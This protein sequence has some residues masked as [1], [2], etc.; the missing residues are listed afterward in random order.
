MR[1]C[2]LLA[3]LLLSAS[4]AAQEHFVRVG[5]SRQLTLDGQPYY[6]IGTNAWYLPI[7]AS[8]GQGGDYRRLAAELNALCKLGVRNLRILVGADGHP[9]ARKVQP[10]L[11]TAPGEYNDTLL[12]GLDRLLVEMGKRQMKA[13]L[14]LNNSWSWSG[15]YTS[16]IHWSQGDE[17]EVVDTIEWKQ[18]CNHAALF[19]QDAE[20]RHLFMRHVRAI[21]S[22]RN[23]LTGIPYADDPAIMAWQIGNEPRAF[24]E[25][26][27]EYFFRWIGEAAALIKQYDPNHLVSVGSEGMMGC[28]LDMNLYERIHRDPCIDYLTIHIW[29]QNWMWVERGKVA[30]KKQKPL[31][32]EQLD[33][34]YKKTEAYIRLHTDVARDLG[35][36]L[37]IEEFGYPRDGNSYDAGSSTIARD[38]Y[39]RFILDHVVRSRDEGGV[40]AGVNFWGWNGQARRRHLWWQPFDPYMADP[41]QEEQGL[42]GVFDCDKTVK[43]IKKVTSQLK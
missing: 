22:R 42:Y 5:D 28:E 12:V 38:A 43:V 6:Y 16:Y 25:L 34:V 30:S 20:A 4:L 2:F 40:L 11:Q 1:L 21:V 26:S 9:T 19:A 39:Y 24:S 27:K 23:S 17:K 10:I 32:R 7:L 14:Y 29:P 31:M 41:A 13:V 8:D 36:P 3:L 37:V 15:G 33:A 35:K 18:W